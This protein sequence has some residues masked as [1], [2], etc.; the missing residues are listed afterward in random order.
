MRQP[1]EVE[2]NLI[3]I[4]SQV[5]LNSCKQYWMWDFPFLKDFSKG[6]LQQNLGS[7][8]HPLDPD[9]QT[10]ISISDSNEEVKSAPSKNQLNLLLLQ[11]YEYETHNR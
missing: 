2:F 8:S 5:L 11:S 7:G 1:S 4:D 3:C 6:S 10:I 9:R